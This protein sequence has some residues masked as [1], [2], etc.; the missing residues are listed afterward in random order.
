MKSSRRFVLYLSILFLV[1]L[2]LGA[3]SVSAQ[4]TIFSLE[5]NTGNTPSGTITGWNE[6]SLVSGGAS[7]QSFTF[8]PG[9]GNVTVSVSGANMSTGATVAIDTKGRNTFTNSNQTAGFTQAALYNGFFFSAGTG[10]KLIVSLSG[11]GVI[12]PST[13]YSLTVLAE[14]PANSGTAQGTSPGTVYFEDGSGNYVLGSPAASTIQIL[15]NPLSGQGL[16]V[17][18][19]PRCQITFNLT[20]NASGV[21]TF[22]DLDGTIAS[23][24]RLTGIVLSKAASTYTWSGT[25]GGSV[26]GTANWTNSTIPAGTSPM[27]MFGNN[28]TAPA[29]VTLDSSPTFGPLT[30]SNSNNYGY[31]LA[32]GS[33]G[34]LTL[35]GL[36]TVSN[37]TNTISTPVALGAIVPVNIASGA[38]LTIS[39][40]ISGSRV[41]LTLGGSGLLTLAGANTYN[42]NTYIGGGVLS[43][44]NSAALASGG[45][46]I[47]A[48]GTLQFSANNTQDY[49]SNI[50]YSTGPIAI[51]TNGQSVTF[52][53]ALASSNAGGM[54][55]IGAGALSLLAVCNYTGT[56]TVNGGTLQLNTNN[57]ANG[58]LASSPSVIV[59]AGA[60]LAL[61][62]N[63]VLGLTTGRNALTINDGVVSNITGNLRVTIYNQINMTGGTLS[64]TGP[65]DANGDYSFDVQSIPLDGFNATSD[66]SGN[67]AVVNAQEISLESHT[68]TVNVTRG[69]ANPAADMIISSNI[70]PYNGS[71]YGFI[72]TGNGILAL[73]GSNTY[74]GATSITSGTL[75][76]GNG[77]ATGSLSVSSTISDSGTLAFSRSNAVTQGIDFSGL[78]IAGSGNLVQ[79]GPGT[80]TLNAANSY[81]GTTSVSG[82]ALLLNSGSLNSTGAVSV[83]GGATFGG[84]GAAGAVTVAPGGILQSGYNGAGGLSL[85]GLTFSGSGSVNLGVLSTANTSSPAISIGSGGLSTSGA[86]SI[87]ITVGSLTGAASGVAYQL[88]SYGSIGGSGTAAF[89]LAPL[90]SRALGYLSFPAGL[91]DLNVTGADYLHWSG[92]VSSAWD[93]TSANW[94]L[95]STGGTT[96]F[97]NG[98][99]STGGDTVLFD[100]FAGQGNSSVTLATTVYPSS[101]TVSSSNNYTFSGSGSIG[102]VTGV[103]INGPGSVTLATSN[104]YTGGTTILGGNVTGLGNSPLGSG[105]VVMSPTGTATLFFPGPASTIGTLSSTGA[106]SSYI[107]LGSASSALAA[108]L[109]INNTAAATFCGAIGDLSASN[110]AATGALVL[111]GNSALTLTG[112]NTYTGGTTLSAGTLIAANNSALGT[113][114]VAM[115]PPSGTAVLAFNTAA[116]SIGSLAG[117]GAGSSLVVLGNSSAPAATTLTVGGDDASTTFSGTIGD[118]IATNSAAAGSIVKTGTGTW[119]LSPNAPNSYSGGTVVNQGTVVLNYTNLGA[120]IGTISGPLTINP[121]ATVVVTV[122]KGIGFANVSSGGVTTLSIS[123]GL[124]NYT[125]SFGV[126]P[127]G[128]GGGQT[129]YLTGGTIQTNGGVSSPTATSFYRVLSAV[130][131]DN[132]YSIYTLASATPSVMSGGIELSSSATFNVAS[133]GTL[134]VSAAMFNNV[135]GSTA[136]SITQTG[137]G[138]LVLSGDNTYGGATTV[139]G[140]TLELAAGGAQGS[141][142]ASAITV[143]TGATLLTAAQDATGYASTAALVIAGT[144]DKGANVGGTGA[145]HETL[146]RPTALVGG[147]ITA[148]DSGDNAL[149]A[150]PG[151]VYNF[152]GLALS[153]SANSGTSYITLP[154]GGQVL[155]RENG[156]TYP[157]FNLGASSSLVVNCN[158][159]DYDAGGDPLIVNGAGAMLLLGSNTYSG[160]T[161]VGGGTLQLGN[162]SALGTGGLTA[163]AGVVDLEGYSLTAAN[164]NALPSLAGAAGTI[165]D[166]GTGGGTTTLTVSQSI[167]TTFGGSI[168]DGPVNRL[169][170]L[171]TGTGTLILS[172]TNDYSGGTIVDAGTLIVDD[173]SALLDGSSLTVGQGASSLF[174]PALRGPPSPGGAAAPAG[175]AAVPE[176]QTLALLAAGAAILLMSGSCWRP[177]GVRRSLRG[178]Y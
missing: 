31:T 113:G 72:E 33:G 153:T 37:G 27:V 129:V 47:F 46:I 19:D 76:L 44:A 146:A 5:T 147:T 127:Y 73:T 7:P 81:S 59:N 87:T 151:Q 156:G 38:A 171:L 112:S 41:G 8:N 53:N 126:S 99:V 177:F 75:Q 139:S 106:G 111:I 24:D 141:I 98:A 15:G 148:S 131:P 18:N 74:V 169:A 149:S 34:T 51:D 155:L 89:Q 130:G 70:A 58:Q 95:D 90:P 49:S 140:G 159:A 50:V 166:Y 114:T 16:L 3:G 65:G 97:I 175:A 101:V 57:G 25:G 110:P 119:T 86:S 80:L 144:L 91:V 135:G 160:G 35:N 6:W 23:G 162:V 122:P 124:L 157:T 120:N 82:G 174:G 43:L 39:G 9:P 116:P 96:A 102:G 79:M 152:L 28:I 103:T 125:G 128:L 52:N 14:D 42:Y 83:A 29:T 134:S 21:L 55:K 165:T 54:T 107:V 167:T 117:N 64:A 93:T 56:T 12:A 145:N 85:A 60:C 71:T 68:L 105:P 173:A 158:L 154:A 48:G 172:G 20:S 88:L 143:A 62:T 78:A 17:N 2:G 161:Y 1:A 123:G 133:G 61:N 69:P 36:V 94:T 109:T 137:S 11:A 118:L 26:T 10:T 121:G 66:A 138:L 67:P 168:D 136:G 170:L 92:A 176:P 77:G 178:R 142:G 164:S 45:P 100:N 132:D 163:N 22:Q 150:S 115:N 104:S 84:A 108:T 40:P 13:Q 63:D 32:P 4:T 30:F